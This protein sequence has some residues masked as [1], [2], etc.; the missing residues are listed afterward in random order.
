MGLVVV[1]GGLI[2]DIVNILLVLNAIAGMVFAETRGS[3]SEA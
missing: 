2:L 1:E 3:S